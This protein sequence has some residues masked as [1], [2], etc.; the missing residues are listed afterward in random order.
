VIAVDTNLL[1]Y[2]HR[3]G[4]PEHRRA[5]RA[6]ENAASSDRGWGIALA[7][8]G[9]FWSIVTHP[10][11]GGGKQAGRRAAAFLRSLAEDADMLVWPPG[12][13]FEG[14]L[15]QHALEL[16]VRGARMFDLQIALVA[17]EH[18]AH[19]IW[20]HDRGFV[21]IKGVSVHDPLT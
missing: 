16:D 19:E 13:G 5:R 17:L 18:G 2:A 6:I 11:I 8:V 3:S 21:R 15:V 20:T 4:T 10:L 9:E 1:V 14:R 12:P 7:S